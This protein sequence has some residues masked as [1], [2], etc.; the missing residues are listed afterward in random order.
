M[1][2]Q[3]RIDTLVEL[4]KCLTKDNPA[5]V[6]AVEQAYIQNRWFTIENCWKAIENITEAFLEK[7]KLENWAKAY[8]IGPKTPKTVGLVM[9]GNIPLV[10]F[11][12]FLSVFVAGHKAMV[13]LSDK[14]FVLMKFV[15]KTLIEINPETA[16]YIEETERLIDFNAVIATGSNNTARYFE[17]YFGQYP[18]I[19]RKNRTSIAVLTGQETEAELVQL[20]ID[21]FEYFGLG[22]RNVSK[23]YIPKDYDFEP[24]MKAFHLFNEIVLHNKYKNNYDYSYTLLTMNRIP[25]IFGTCLLLTESVNL[26]PRIAQMYYSYYDNL[27]NLN[28]E[29]LKYKEEIQCVVSSNPIDNYQIIPFGNTQKPSLS[30][31]ADGVDTMAFL[32]EAVG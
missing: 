21:V 12:D 13:K 7:N 5:L 18:N 27:Q 17:A 6:L 26:Q 19:I 2:L 23:I 10:G 16:Y 30:D 29:L 9:A 25:T 14:D 31:Y 28:T 32:V 8:N 3:D 15:F 4:G 24:M 11:H 20:G 1:T 22:C